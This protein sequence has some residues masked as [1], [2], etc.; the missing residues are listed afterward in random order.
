MTP[1]SLAIEWARLVGRL[2]TLP[3]TGWVRRGVPHIESVADHSWRVAALAMLT[4]NPQK[5]MCMAVVHDIAECIIG[6]IAPDDCVSKEDKQKREHDAT[7]QIVTMLKDASG[8]ADMTFLK[9]LLEE[10]EERTTPEAIAVKDL[11]LLDMIIQADEYETRYDQIDLQDFFDGTPVSRFRTPKLAK[12]AAE[13]HRQR[14]ERRKHSA[15][16]T[17]ST[18]ELSKRDTDFVRNYAVKSPLSEAQIRDVIVEL[19]KSER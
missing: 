6:D 17:T 2:K 18:S 3:R 1:E 14:Q 5:C 15:P 16:A 12:V 7:E 13:V 9:S 4:D 11:D 19:R 8:G 10:Y